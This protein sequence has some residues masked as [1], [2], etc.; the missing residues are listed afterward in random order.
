MMTPEMIDAVLRSGQ[1]DPQ[2]EAYK[3]QQAMI[4]KLRERSMTPPQQQMSGR[5]VQPNWGQAV[6][7]LV[8]GYQA[9]KMQPQADAVLGSVNNRQ[10]ATKK[11]YFDALMQALRKEQPQ[12]QQPAP[13]PEPSYGPMGGM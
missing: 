13:V 6:S 12:P 4:N 11:A 7:S 9:N 10:V 5:L 2:M 1:M 8:G 3:R